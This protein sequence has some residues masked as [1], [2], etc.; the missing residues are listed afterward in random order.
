MTTNGSGVSVCM[1]IYCVYLSMYMYDICVD[2]SD[3]YNV[4]L[5]VGGVGVGVGMSGGIG[6]VLE[7]TMTSSNGR[8]ETGIQIT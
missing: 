5:E 8:S 4:A 6:S 3:R 1:Y 7:M 2:L